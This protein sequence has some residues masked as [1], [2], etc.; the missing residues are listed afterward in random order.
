M[1][2]NDSGVEVVVKPSKAQRSANFGFA[3]A[4][5]WSIVVD[6]GFAI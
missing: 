3:V 2:V 1:H 4:Y 6:L 5:H